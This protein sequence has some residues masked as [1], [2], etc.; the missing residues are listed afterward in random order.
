MAELWA[1][2]GPQVAELVRHSRESA[3]V[4]QETADRV[5]RMG[6]RVAD[7][8]SFAL[9]TRWAHEELKEDLGRAFNW[10]RLGFRHADEKEKRKAW[11]EQREQEGQ[12]AGEGEGEEAAGS[13]AAEEEDE[14]RAAES[15]EEREKKAEKRRKVKGKG[16]AV[17]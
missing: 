16:R 6:R 15:A 8:R 7:T 12:P 1:V 4:L 2:L 5:E 10:A 13:A 3:K 14:E 9:N 11:K 17:D